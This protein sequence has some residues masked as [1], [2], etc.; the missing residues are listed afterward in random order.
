M[1]RCL[2][3]FPVLET[4]KHD[5]DVLALTGKAETDDPEH[6][7][8]DVG[9]LF[10]I[11]ILDLFQHIQRAFG[12]GPRR[13]LD[14]GEQDALIL[15]GQ[16]PLRR[17]HEQQAHGNKDANIGQ[18]GQEPPAHQPA[19][20]LAIACHQLVKTPV[21]HTEQPTAFLVAFGFQQGCA[22]RRRQG[23]RHKNRQRHGRN[24]RHRELFVNHAG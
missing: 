1:V 22:Q 23:Q 20:G 16:E 14:Q 13:A 5:T 24:D 18:P 6:G 2:A 12:R 21:E 17:A 15:V 9:F 4:H 10:Q 7:I 3:V 19:H 8:H 11:V